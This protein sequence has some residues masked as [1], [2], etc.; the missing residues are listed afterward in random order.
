MSRLMTRTR[1]L[2]GTAVLAVLALAGAW[3]W[4]SR[5]ATPRAADQ[6]VRLIPADTAVAI[7]TPVTGETRDAWW[8]RV[9]DLAPTALGYTGTELRGQRGV[10]AVGYS[11]GT[12]RKHGLELDLNQVP[13][14]YVQASSRAGARAV[15]QAL[16]RTNRRNARF[17]QIIGTVVVST[18]AYTTPDAE[19]AQARA[20][21]LA[22]SADYR[23][24]TA[25][26]QGSVYWLNQDAWGTM[27]DSPA[28]RPKVVAR[29]FTALTGLTHQTRWAGT[30]ASPDA[31]WHGTFV[32][33]GFSQKSLA[34]QN[35]ASILSPATQVKAAAQD[36]S[37]LALNV[38]VAQALGYGTYATYPSRDA[39]FGRSALA[40]G[41]DRVM[42]DKD[43][44]VHLLM[45]PGIL[46]AAMSASGTAA[47]TP[48]TTLRMDISG[49]GMSLT[50]Q[51][52]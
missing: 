48:T 16:V 43:S 38:N 28:G 4:V 21:S 34:P 9:T 42:G 18:P 31:P 10:Q 29:A 49:S 24:A 37:V 27:A 32:R 23:R 47:A 19:T 51:S 8:G 5:D 1:V 30:A 14:L 2:I 52:K 15:A 12:T 46:T 40:A 22:G 13:V 33:G 3:L 44:A 50:Q 25:R 6:I 45:D 41:Q 26:A 7:D 17:A 20:G 35:A 36:G 39:D 11:L